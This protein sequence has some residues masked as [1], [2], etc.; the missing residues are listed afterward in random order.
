M[1]EMMRLELTS[2]LSLLSCSQSKPETIYRLHPYIK[3]AETGGFEPQPA[4]RQCVMQ[5]LHHG[6][7]IYFADSVGFEP[8]MELSFGRLTV[9]YHRPLGHKPKLKNW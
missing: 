1:L 6:L 9:C 5:P 7:G 4:H 8:T 2:S 3:V